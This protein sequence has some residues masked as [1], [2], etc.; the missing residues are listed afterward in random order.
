MRR[1]LGQMDPLLIDGI[2]AFAVFALMAG[3]LIWTRHLLAGQHPTTVLTWLLAVL[4]CAPMPSRPC[5]R[6]PS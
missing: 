2:A 6:W 1:A 4:I 5:S 3:Q